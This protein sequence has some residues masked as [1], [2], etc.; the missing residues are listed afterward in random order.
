MTQINSI[1]VI[2]VDDHRRVHQVIAEMISYMDGIE[3]LAQ[4]CNGLEAIELC[5]QYQPD[6]ILM[7]VV[8]PVMDGVKATRHILQHQ[9]KTRIL[10]F[11]SFNDQE[12]TRAMLNNGATGFVLKDSS[13]ND[14]EHTI[15]TTYEGQGILSPEILGVLL[16]NSDAPVSASIQLTAR[17][18]EILHLLADGLTNGAIATK[19]TISVSTVKFH[20][21][22][23]LEKFGVDTRAEALV[24][25]AKCNLV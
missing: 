2:L 14:L 3:L 13:V 20:I 9:P 25:A 1:G 6:V 19:L 12:T 8:M 16:Q 5:N 15:R 4:G 21:N 22:N 17:E 18:L 23:I 7:D 24:M 11:S 10:A